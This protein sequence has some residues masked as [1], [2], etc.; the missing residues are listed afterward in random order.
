MD[1]KVKTELIDG[2]DQLA[3][4][5]ATYDD[6]RV[7]II[8]K[9]CFRIKIVENFYAVEG[10]L[11]ANISTFLNYR[12]FNYEADQLKFSVNAE[13]VIQLVI[14]GHG[15]RLTMASLRYVYFSHAA[16]SEYRL[17]TMSTTARRKEITLYNMRVGLHLLYLKY[18]NEQHFENLELRAAGGSARA[19]ARIQKRF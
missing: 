4:T 18:E 19:N 7:E 13:N 11:C 16:M 17:Y 3:V 8:F 10:Y 5:S 14:D 15:I 9:S 2:F 1:A 12:T 6:G